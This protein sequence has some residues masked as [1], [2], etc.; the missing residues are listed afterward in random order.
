MFMRK[1]KGDKIK[2]SEKVRGGKSKLL[3]E[4]TIG[5]LFTILE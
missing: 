4:G 1:R 3:D 5:Y 2:K